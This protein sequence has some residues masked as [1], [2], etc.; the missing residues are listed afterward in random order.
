M[1]SK[2]SNKF[3]EFSKQCGASTLEMAIVVA[4]VAVVAVL[5][6]TKLGEASK[7]Q[8]VCTAVY[9]SGGTIR[10][11]DP[12]IDPIIVE[13]PGGSSNMGPFSDIHCPVLGGSGGSAI[14]GGGD[15]D[16][17]GDNDDCLDPNFCDPRD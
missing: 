11:G 9:V 16:G 6:I 10:T 14:H 1:K 17:D 2:K 5:P 8:V 7:T 3:I 13:A 4:S 12:V 15:G